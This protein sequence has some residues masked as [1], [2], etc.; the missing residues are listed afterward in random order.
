MLQA[1][2]L[3]AQGDIPPALVPLER[4]LTLAQP[5]GYVRV[6]LGEEEPMRN[7]LR[8]ATAS[9]IASSYTQ[10]LLTAFDFTE[11][12]VSKTSGRPG[13]PGLVEP[14]TERETEVLRL[15]S[16]GMTNQEIAGQLVISVATV[17]RH[18][19]NIYGKLG[20]GHRTQA[21]ARANELNLL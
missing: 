13:V 20:V 8:H 19:T 15:I 4:A 6:F 5:E 18:I 2:A 21:T 12:P 14:L 9:G 16:V 11:Q 17:K 10:R 7:L 1:L 3:E